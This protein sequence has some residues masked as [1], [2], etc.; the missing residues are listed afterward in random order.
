MTCFTFISAFFLKCNFQELMSNSYEHIL[1]LNI[2]IG[3]LTHPG[4]LNHYSNIKRG[5][6]VKFELFIY[7]RQRLQTS[8]I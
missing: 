6:V 1:T 2:L 3:V 5:L 8:Y 4:G 7:L